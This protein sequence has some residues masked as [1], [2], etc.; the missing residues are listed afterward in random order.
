MYCLIFTQTPNARL[1]MSVPLQQK[2]IDA[3]VQLRKSCPITHDVLAYYLENPNYVDGMVGLRWSV[4]RRVGADNK[5][6]FI[7][8]AYWE[9]CND[10]HINSFLKHILKYEI[11]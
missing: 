11:K 6:C 7:T 8:K 2:I 4:L 1:K 10:D 3:I 5:C 9:G